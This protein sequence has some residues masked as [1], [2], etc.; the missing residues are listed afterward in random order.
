MLSVLPIKFHK[1]CFSLFPDCLGISRKEAAWFFCSQPTLAGHTAALD[2][3]ALN[4]YR[5]P[6]PSL[7]QVS[8]NTSS[9]RE[10]IP[11][12]LERLLVATEFTLVLPRS[13]HSLVPSQ[14]KRPS[15]SQYP[16]PLVRNQPSKVSGESRMDGPCDVECCDPLRLQ[17]DWLM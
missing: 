8:P 9:G 10:Q 3:S 17:E 1:N 13:I 15:A 7:L 11:H 5:H 12:I 16:M 2:W 4:H 14:Y 6:V